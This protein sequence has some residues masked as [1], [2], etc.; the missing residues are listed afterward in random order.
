VSTALRLVAAPDAGHRLDTLAEQFMGQGQGANAAKA[1]RRAVAAFVDRFVDLAGWADA[2]VPARLSAPVAVRGFAAW[3]ALSCGQPVDAAYVAAS[4]SAWGYQAELVF[5][6]FAAAF[7]TVAAR[8]GF[9]SK[10]IQRQWA[11][12]AKLAAVA[13]VAP[14]QLDRPRF[15]R[16]QA[17]LRHAILAIHSGQM[18]NTFTTPLH[19]L[20][21]TLAA[22]NVLDVPESRN[23][24]DRGR[25]AHWERIAAHTPTSA[26]TMRRYLAQLA[27]S[28]RPGSVALVDTTL[29]HLA[30]YLIDHHPEVTTVAGVGRTHIE[31][32]KASL[33]ARAGYRGRRAQV[34]TTIGMRLGHLRGFFDRIIEWDYQ[35][36]PSRNPVFAGD[37]PIKDRPLPRF[38]DDADAAKLLAAARALPE[39]FD[40][41]CVEVLA[42]TGIRRGEFLALSTDAIVR[43]GTNDWLRTPVGKMHTDRYIPLH[44]RVKTLLTEWLTHRGEQ[45]RSRLMFVERGRAMPASRVDRAVARAATAAGLGHIHPHQLRHTLA[46]QAINRGMS[47]EAIAALLGHTSMSMTMTYA[48][49]ADRT[50]AD[51]YFA[52]T[53][54]VE[55]LYHAASLPAD[56]EGP[57]MRRLHAEASR[58]L[59]GNGY[60]TRPAEIGCR[61]ETICE[62]CTFFATTIAFRDQIQAQ[63]DDAHRHADHDRKKI[64]NNLLDRLDKTGT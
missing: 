50:V 56:A 40:R 1:R 62:G 22:L 30:D 37:M 38:L 34:K 24:P 48:R 35:D 61:Y 16:A 20:Q 45:P 58:R 29:R 4:A 13:G 52:V 15:D 49:I 59:L 36:A 26:A 63:H 53:G 47:L 54:K 46:T 42:R 14:A 27:I 33:A 39:L 10:E 57:N 44:P 60:C 23:K 9:T 64:Y 17:T 41:V 11:T 51:E 3:L 21:A 6:E 55:A 19:G 28:L 32:F 5:A 31:G 2:P 43:I 18:P 8:L 25:G 7:R 12:A